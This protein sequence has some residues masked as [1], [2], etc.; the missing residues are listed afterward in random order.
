MTICIKI[1][2]KIIENS[3]PF[4]SGNRKSGNEIERLDL[5]C[6]MKAAE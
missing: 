1:N 2:L 6:Q 5:S 4:C 3:L